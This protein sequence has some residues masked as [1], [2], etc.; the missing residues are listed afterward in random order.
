MNAHK[1]IGQVANTFVYLLGFLILATSATIAQAASES[2]AQPVKSPPGI[3]HIK[4][5]VF[6]VK[7]NRTYDNMFGAFNS[8][9]GTQTCKTST[10]QL[11]PMHRAPDRYPHNVNHNWEDAVLAM[12]GGKMDRFDLISLGTPL[13][14]SLNGDF[15]TCSQFSEADIPNYFAYAREFTLGVAMFSSL[16]GP[17]F[18]N[19]LYTIAAESGG[20]MDNPGMSPWGCD[21]PDDDDVRVLQS[22]GTI[23]NEFPC[24]SF[25]TMAQ[26]LDNAGVS[27]KYYGPPSSDFGYIWSTFDAIDYVRNGA[28]WSNVVDTSTFITNVENNRLPSVSWLVTPFWQSEHPFV[29]TQGLH[30]STCEGENATVTELNAIM[31][32]SSIW[33]STAVFIVWDDFGGDYDHVAPPSLDAFGL[34]PRVPLLV[35]SPYAKKGYIS[36]TQYEFSSI[37]KFIEERFNLPP[38][39]DRDT[40]AND[41]SGSFNFA[42]NPSPPLILKTRNCPLLSAAEITMG[43]AVRGV[44]STALTQALDVYNSRP[45]ALTINS[46]TSS[47]PQFSV[48]GQSCTEAAIDC[49]T[50]KVHYCSVGTELS[51]QTVDGSCTPS[52][53]ICVTFAPTTTGKISGTIT[54]HDT[55]S[56]SPQSTIVHGLGA[57]VQLSPTLLHFRN[58]VLGHSSTLPVEL[59]NVGKN[60]LSIRSIRAVS[61]YTATNNCG[62]SVPANGSCTINV[63]F[64]PHASGSWP[65]ALQI[66][67]SDPASPQRVDLVGYGVGVVFKPSSLKFAP[68]TVGTTSPPQPVIITNRNSSAIVIAGV[69]AAH[70]FVLSSNNCPDTLD[71]K[72]SCTVQVEFSPDQKGPIKSTLSISDN[73]PSSPQSMSLSG[74]GQ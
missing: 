54:V 26:T 37:L 12:D 9:Y 7:E 35:I 13:S 5:I 73:D 38:L 18:P 21:G 28:D 69:Q 11:I 43:T 65:G 51:P 47:S 71:S 30:T 56:S 67:S 10:G 48:A 52:C 36:N 1:F 27:W 32:N 40:Q 29:A 6:I 17:S 41:I 20:V 33:D 45:T 49:S 14:G 2:A 55:D 34:G 61:D 16:H 22:D 53:S 68:Q 25:A 50:G 57:L 4:H 44:P 46:I 70:D 64:F 58:Q 24:F 59:T 63:K 72:K 23:A 31:N 42:Q 62:S 3:Q 39:G 8:N 74:T 66:V 19:H 15:L 60:A